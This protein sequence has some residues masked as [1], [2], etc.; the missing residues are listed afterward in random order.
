MTSD[1]NDADTVEYTDHNGV[2]VTLDDVANDGNNSDEELVGQAR[3]NVT[4]GREHHGQPGRGHPR[5][6]LGGEPPQR[7][8][9]ERHAE[10]RGQ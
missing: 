1:N 2:T 3:D 9:L 7:T 10:G 4:P 5:R 8:G 6:E